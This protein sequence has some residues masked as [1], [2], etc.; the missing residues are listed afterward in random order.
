MSLR[1]EPWN[2]L[3]DTH[4]AVLSQREQAASQPFSFDYLQNAILIQTRSEESRR[5]GEYLPITGVLTDPAAALGL[6]QAEPTLTTDLPDYTGGQQWGKISIL[7]QD[8][9]PGEIAYGYTSGVAIAR[10]KRRYA[11][12]DHCDIDPNNGAILISHPS[13]SWQIIWD[14]AAPDPNTP[15]EGW[16]ILRHRGIWQRELKCQVPSDGELLPGT[17]GLVNVSFG[18]L[19]P[20]ET[21]QITVSH[22]WF[23]QLG[24]PIGADS[25]I[26]AKWFPDEL[27]WVVVAAEC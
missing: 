23:D 13:G 1:A 15:A 11:Y 6:F 24:N 19:P 12:H 5:V 2:D 8:S 20:D 17:S 9:A 16:A 27:K 14:N 25:K 26:L 21:K 3:I 22:N 7:A 18:G 4:Q 10:L